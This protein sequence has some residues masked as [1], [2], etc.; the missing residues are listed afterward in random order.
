[1]KEEVRQKGKENKKVQQTLDEMEKE[2]NVVFQ[3]ISDSAEPE[4]VSSE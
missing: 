1:L 2:I 3:A 4:E